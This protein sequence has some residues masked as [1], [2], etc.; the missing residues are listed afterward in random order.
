[1]KAE[2]ALEKTNLY[3]LDAVSIYQFSI[4]P[5]NEGQSMTYQENFTGSLEDLFL[6]CNEI[7]E[8][9]KSIFPAGE[10]SVLIENS[11]FDNYVLYVPSTGILDSDGNL[12]FSFNDQNKNDINRTSN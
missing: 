6:R 11:A 4:T 3:N 5:C 10:F 9:L 7:V 1:M 12:L 8:G 2:T